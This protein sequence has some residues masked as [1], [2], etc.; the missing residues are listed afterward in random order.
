[1]API[2]HTLADTADRHR[3]RH[4]HA[5][6]PAQTWPS[7]ARTASPA[8]PTRRAGARSSRCRPTTAADEARVR[9]RRSSGG[10]ATHG[11]PPAGRPT[12]DVAAPDA[13]LRRRP[14]GARLRGRHRPRRSRRSWPA[15]S[16]C[17]GSRTR[18]PTAPAGQPY[19]LARRR[20]G[21]AAVVLP[22]GQRRPT[23]ELL[24]VAAQRPARRAPARSSSRCARMLADPRSEAL[25]TR[26]AAQWLRL[27]D[28]DEV[29]P[30]AILYP[31][32]DRTLGAGAADAR[33]SCS[34]TAW[35]A[36]T[37]ACSTCSPPTTRSS[38]SGWRG[39]TASRTS[40]APQFRRVTVPE[41]RARHPRPRQRA[42]C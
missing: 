41:Y 8:S 20:A 12:R 37:A 10:L 34:S 16:S 14:P 11:V 22:L 6:A 13:L 29:S 30:D 1:M 5:A 39:T 17:S 31:Y 9:H 18:R 4:H 38:T 24:D 36:R 32:Y 40:P 27:Q 42:D 19:R 35:C 33:P 7:S 3:L 28:V 15:R 23:P 26:F 25:A 2:E 21:L